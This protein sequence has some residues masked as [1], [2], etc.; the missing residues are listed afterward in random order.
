MPTWS[1]KRVE[2][3]LLAVLAILSV[4]PLRISAESNVLLAAELVAIAF[5]AL[6]ATLG[7][8]KIRL[9][10]SIAIPMVPIFF[11]YLARLIAIPIA[12]EMTA[13][14]VFGCVALTFSVAGK[15]NR[16][17]ALSLVTGG[18]LVLF[19]AS[20][21][22]DRYAIAYPLVW[23]L[24]CV[25]HL[26]ANH[27]ERLDLAMPDTVTRNWSMRPSTML[28]TVL[29]LS[30]GAY[31][32]KDRFAGP[33][34]ATF[35]FMPTSGGSSWSDPAAR[36]GVGSGEAA[37][38]AKDRA[39]SFGAVESELFL[40]S[41]ESTLFD[42][43]NDMVGEPKK[44]KVIHE[45][46]QALGNENLIPSHEQNSKSEQGGGS[47]S[48]DRMPPEKHRHF[49]NAIDPSAVQWD[50]P[51]GIRLAMHRYDTFDGV[52]WTQSADLSKDSLSR[53][54]FGDTCWFF[55]PTMRR[56]VQTDPD[57]VSV[58]LLKV[59]RLKSPRLP[60]PMMAAGV[61]V[62]DI[63]RQDFFA[64]DKDGSYF[65]P[66]REKV[67][68]LTVL[69]VSHTVPSEDSIREGLKPIEVSKDS[70]DRDLVNRDITEL[71]DKC[72]GDLEHPR[73]Q[74]C[75]I[76]DHLRS[77]FTFD[78]DHVGSTD[79]ALHHFIQSRRGGDHLF[80][81]TAALM[82]REIGLRSRLVTG[83]YVR[84]DAFDV[85]AGHSRV[86]PSDVHVWA[87][88][89]LTDGRWFEIEPTPGYL[90]PDYRPSL[91]LRTKQLAAAHWASASIAFSLFV[92]AFLSRRIWIEWILVVIWSLSRFVSQRR[93]LR[94]A[95]QIIETRAR[96]AGQRRP[97]GKS[98][99]SWLEHLTAG[100]ATLETATGQFL[101][102]ADALFFGKRSLSIS[103]SATRLVGLL[104]IQTFSR[105]GKEQAQ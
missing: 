38:A 54:D 29:V 46:R 9:G 55:D 76:V 85:V 58:G 100:D 45:R 99:R 89:Q 80:A 17:Q 12:Y 94:L 73:D 70:V 13:L 52:D 6:L 90:Q 96:L 43:F 14:S 4:T 16:M 88:V 91:W 2:T 61:H 41:S 48:T 20:I 33:H 86:L 77:E 67:P 57:S 81:T 60:V 18:F 104:R 92:I 28:L 31:A 50:G 98:Q 24:G 102:A 56:H 15:T 26:I 35:G 39:D 65:M 75:A 78:R 97:V 63:D 37:I 103:P 82:A 74:L 27:W 83:F 19:C 8:S 32:A 25:W 7:V 64:I 36:S 22:D 53:V 11:A 30:A 62:K 3:T 5:A 69:H 21:S 34:R 105:L 93:K 68:P 87:E 49:D 51:T 44:R 71:A 66:G 42:M 84:P 40:E 23:M 10:A 79:S 101:D 47:F 95:M 72:A 59:I 1:R